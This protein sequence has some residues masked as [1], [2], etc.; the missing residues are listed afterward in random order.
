MFLVFQG[1]EPQLL[2]LAALAMIHETG[3]SE[4]R[5]AIGTAVVALQ[6]EGSIGDEVTAGQRDAFEA[7]FLTTEEVGYESDQMV[8]A[9]LTGG[10]V[11]TF[12]QGHPVEI[13][14]EGFIDHRCDLSQLIG[15]NLGQGMEEL[16][17][18]TVAVFF[19]PCYESHHW[20][21]RFIMACQPFSFDGQKN[22]PIA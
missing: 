6:R 18:H 2:Q 14:P 8:H 3:A 12:H 1:E 19:Q 13:N 21:R 15:G 20:H 11:P 9:G 5:A 7:S 10:S 17:A 22:C 16:F 4:Q